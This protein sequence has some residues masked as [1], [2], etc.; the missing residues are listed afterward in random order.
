MINCHKGQSKSLRWRRGQS[1]GPRK[2]KSCRC[3]TRRR[4]E[5][6]KRWRQKLGD[7]RKLKLSK[8]SLKKR[9]EKDKQRLMK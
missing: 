8:S 6:P 2:D 9:R 3:F 1:K 5:L 7:K 4:K